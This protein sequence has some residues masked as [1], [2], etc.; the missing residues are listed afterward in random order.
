MLDHGSFAYTFVFLCHFYNFFTV[1]ILIYMSVQKKKAAIFLFFIF[2][3]LIYEKEK[4]S[5]GQPS[6]FL[7]PAPHFPSFHFRWISSLMLCTIYK[8]G[9]FHLHPATSFPEPPYLDSRFAI[10]GLTPLKDFPGFV[11]VFCF[12]S[13]L[14][15]LLLSGF[16]LWNISI[17][18]FMTV[19]L[20]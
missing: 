13:L 10:D 3:D 12:L 20:G 11:F 8:V 5:S 15:Y 2:V 14:F 17:Y 4:K 1:Q 19:C 9:P 6:F 16:L 7:L 18:I